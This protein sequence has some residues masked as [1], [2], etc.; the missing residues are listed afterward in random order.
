MHPALGVPVMTTS[1]FWKCEAE[2]EKRESADLIGDFYKDI[3]ADQYAATQEI[4]NNTDIALNSLKEYYNPVYGDLVTFQ[5]VQIVD[6]YNVSVRYN[7]RSSTTSFTAIVLCDDC[8]T[9]TL[10]Y[11]ETHYSGSY[12]DPPDYDNS[13]IEL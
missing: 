13:C 3:S 12:Y 2:K 6:I 11:T 1:E 7:M 5:P 4:I 10:A 8:V 9:R